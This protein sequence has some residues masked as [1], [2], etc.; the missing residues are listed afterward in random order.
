MN[1][2]TQ[3]RVLL[4]TNAQEAL[5]EM[6]QE[7]KDSGDFVKI[8]PSRLVSWIVEGFKKESFEKKKDKI[9]QDHFN[10]K[11]YLRDLAT[12]IQ[13]SDNAADILANALQKIQMR[14]KRTNVKKAKKER[15][16]EESLPE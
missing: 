15:I 6:L 12:K 11:E 3:F 10:S 13:S 1:K 4:D 2:Q 9:I 14:N 5:T 16:A 7:L 8:N